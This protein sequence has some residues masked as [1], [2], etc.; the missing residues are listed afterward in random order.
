MTQRKIILRQTQS[1]GDILTFT[2]AVVD[3]VKS[4]PD[5]MVDVRS[6][7]P[8]IWENCPYLT[9]LDE[10]EA[11]VF[12]I[13]Y[14]RDGKGIHE[15]SWSGEHW[16]DAY[17]HDVERQ[18]GVEIKKTAYFPELWVSE[19]EQ[20]W[21]N[22][23]ETEFG[24]DGA[25]WLLNA[26][27]KPDNELK[28]YHRWQEVVYLFNDMFKGSVRLVQIGHKGHN[29]PE[30]QDVYNLVG[31][32]D[33]RQLIRLAWW[34]HGSVGPLSLQFVISAAFQQPHVVVAGGK[35]SVR[36][37][38]Y[39]NGRYLHTNGALECCKWEGCWLGGSQGK[40]L[41]LL[42]GVPRCFTV[43]TPRMIVDAIKMYYD[44]GVLQTGVRGK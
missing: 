41:D 37:H 5:Y 21:I 40:C 18:L 12:T 16:T 43:I 32:T 29:H 35:E 6:P 24:W 9:K 27:H 28:Q 10:K 44:G 39:P 30:L 17:R 26:G 25:F 11:E 34:A 14:G 4:Y 2:R 13:E 22:Q 3:L 15:S 1:P 38:L 8:E 19:Q 7:C 20:Q 36:W 31:K 33:L 23:V 42:H